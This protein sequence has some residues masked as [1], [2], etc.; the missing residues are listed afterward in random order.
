[1]IVKKRITKKLNVKQSKMNGGRL[2]SKIRHFFK[3]P[4]GRTE[5]QTK[6]RSVRPRPA[7]IRKRPQ[8][9][10]SGV[11][12]SGP[13]QQQQRPLSAN[14]GV[15]SSGSQKKSNSMSH[16]VVVS[17]TIDSFLTNANRY[18][19]INYF[20]TEYRNERI[21]NLM[22]KPKSRGLLNMFD[23]GEQEQPLTHDEASNFAQKEINAEHLKRK[24]FGYKEL[25]TNLEKLDNKNKKMTIEKF[26][27]HTLNP[28]VKS[29]ETTHLGIDKKDI[30]KFISNLDKYIKYEESIPVT[31]F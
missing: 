19:K 17:P 2:R 11:S 24:A 18:N 8:S 3:N 4:F 29:H 25:M 6:R 13:T 7:S 31:K 22:E 30:R 28:L 12:S 14:S 21:K 15:S 9:A 16:K 1:M 10:N 23:Q 20:N 27:K 26:I 5:K